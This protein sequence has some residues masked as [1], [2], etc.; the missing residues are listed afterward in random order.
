[1][2]IIIIC[3]F[4][5]AVVDVVLIVGRLDIM[6]TSK[7]LYNVYQG[8]EVQFPIFMVKRSIFFLLLMK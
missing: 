8:L 5:T 3:L 2:H 1:M 4:Y 7:M 6:I